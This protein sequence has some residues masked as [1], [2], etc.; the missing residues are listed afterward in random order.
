MRTITKSKPWEEI[1]QMLGKTDKV[2][3]VGCGT[4]ATMCQTGG[5]TQ[6]IEMKSK[7]EG[8]GKKVTGW[9]VL[10]TG[11]DELAKSALDDNATAVNAAD[12][13]LAMHCAFGNQT[14]SL[15]TDKLVYPGVN[16]T[17]IGIEDTPG[18]YIEV[19]RQCGDCILGKAAGFCP[20]VRCSKTLMNG[21]CGGSSNGKCEVSKDIPCVW[22]Q[23]YDR[24]KA[25]NRLDALE[26]ICPIHDWSVAYE[27]G[28]RRFSV[29][30][31]CPPTP[32]K[33]E[34]VK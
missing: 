5:K 31:V 24:L 34:A 13:I 6:V 14:L 20:I 8:I 10:P 11:C 1:V 28:P 4:C 22:Q 12:G 7:L 21:P 23:I 15:Y 25:S 9:M 32:A 18:H 33:T 2:Y 30:S 19:C 3:I 26:T 17:F 27:G 16:T 29:D